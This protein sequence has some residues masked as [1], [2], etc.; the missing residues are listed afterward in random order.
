MTKKTKKII[1]ICIIVL[2]CLIG[3]GVFAVVR[4]PEGLVRILFPSEA[5]YTEYSNGEK[6][7]RFIGTMHIGKQ[8]YYESIKKL[9]SDSKKEGY[10]Y[11][12]ELIL[13]ESETD[14]TLRKNRR[15]LG[16]I[17]TSDNYAKAFDLGSIGIDMVAQDQ[18][19]LL[20]LVNDKDYN[21]DVTVEQILEAYENKYGV[22]TLTEEDYQTPLN[23]A[24][25][26]I[27]DK[28]QVDYVILN[29]RNEHLAKEI[30][31]SSYSKIII[32]YGANHEKG[33]FNL[34]QEADPKWEKVN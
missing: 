7:I 33:V 20:G 4:N 26:E 24:V 30:M 9:I 3:I 29:V 27:E 19:D 5:R 18:M 10:V 22:I 16:F 12:Y 25:S 15:L 23:E 31:N 14:E 2:C 1:L 6:S 13:S 28:E 21:V 34:L 11:F 8:E 17:P 32:T